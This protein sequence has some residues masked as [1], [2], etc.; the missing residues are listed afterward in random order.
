MLPSAE[1]LDPTCVRVRPEAHRVKGD[2]HGRAIQ[3]E[4]ALHRR[5]AHGRDEHG[6]RRPLRRAPTRGCSGSS[7]SRRSSTRRTASSRAS[8]SATATRRRRRAGRHRAGAPHGVDRA[9]GAS[10]WGAESWRISNDAYKIQPRRTRAAR[11]TAL[12]AI[13]PIS[14]T[15]YVCPNR[16][17]EAALQMFDAVIDESYHS[18]GYAGYDLDAFKNR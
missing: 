16:C 11:T 10:P 8:R 14:G 3:L 15:G 13:C 2:P 17:D 5:L 9:L 1:A 4:R 7:S 12:G 6:D 18:A